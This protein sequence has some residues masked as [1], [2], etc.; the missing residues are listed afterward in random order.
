MLVATLFVACD[1]NLENSPD[2][3]KIRIKERPCEILDYVGKPG[4]NFDT[5]LDSI[6]K[7]K[8]KASKV[9]KQPLEVLFEYDDG[10]FYGIIYDD[11]GMYTDVLD[12]KGNHYSRTWYCADEKDAAVQKEA[13]FNENKIFT[14][15]N[16]CA[17]IVYKSRIANEDYLNKNHSGVSE[18]FKC[19]ALMN[20]HHVFF[21][22]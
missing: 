11:C 22:R 7:H 1:E 9:T 5:A 10:E 6:R 3:T 4:N 15:D 12:T 13:V 17:T 8:N 18:V 20:H 21:S 19:K 16:G 14:I 2:L